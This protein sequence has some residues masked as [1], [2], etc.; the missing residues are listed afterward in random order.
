[1]FQTGGECKPGSGEVWRLDHRFP[2]KVLEFCP[3]LQRYVAAGGA[4]VLFQQQDKCGPG[5]GSA[6]CQ[7]NCAA[8]HVLRLRS[9][10]ARA[11]HCRYVR[12]LLGRA[13]RVG[14]LPNIN[15]IHRCEGVVGSP[16]TPQLQ[17]DAGCHQRQFGA[18]RRDGKQRGAGHVDRCTRNCAT[19][20]PSA[21]SRPKAHDM[22]SPQSARRPD[23]RRSRFEAFQN[24]AA[25]L[26]FPTG[27]K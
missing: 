3:L 22:A 9:Q 4:K 7:S 2:Q 16:R 14:N 18:R 5:S 6:R 17:A 25:S 12:N 26:I 20:S 11:E 8:Q 23:P 24:M 27:G 19:T 1:M 15:R 10:A 13:I 21:T